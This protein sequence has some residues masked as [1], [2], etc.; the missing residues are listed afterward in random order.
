MQNS[1]RCVLPERSTSRLRSSRSTSQGCRLS[2]PGLSARHL[3]EGDFQ[4]VEAFVARLVDARR[5]AGR[6][7]EHAGE[8][9]GQRRVV[10]PVGDQ[11][12]QQ[13]GPAQAGLSAGVAAPSVT[14]LPPPVPV[15]RPSSMNFSVPRRVRRA[16]S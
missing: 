7:D 12:H 10:L 5:L 16:S 1:A 6:A 14:W 2:S 13:V 3:L 4:F 11:A 15:W 9:V 8:Q